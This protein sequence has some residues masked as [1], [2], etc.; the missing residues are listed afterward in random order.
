[1]AQSQDGSLNTEFSA[2]AQRHDPPIVER[3]ALRDRLQTHHHP[4]YLNL[5]FH[6][7]IRKGK[8][9]GP[10]PLLKRGDCFHA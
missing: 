6:H 4:R 5:G 8:A 3:S 1:M 7:E 2:D 10:F 9:Q